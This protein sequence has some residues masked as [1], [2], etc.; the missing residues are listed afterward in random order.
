[1]A[2]NFFIDLHL[3]QFQQAL[4]NFKRELQSLR[5]G[6][7]STILVEEVSV[8]AYGSMQPLKQLAS[9]SVPENNAIAISPWDK[10][11]MKDIEVALNKANLGLSI[12]N[13]GDKI[14]AKLPLMTEE[15][16]KAMVKL[17]GAKAEDARIVI[18]KIRDEVKTAIVNAEKNKEITE[19]DKYQNISE[20]DE[21]IAD[22]NKQVDGMREA[23]E[24]EIMTV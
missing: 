14:I 20:L 8:E 19:D 23:K 21:Y 17:L 4:E 3:T 15:N 18:R 2:R 5:T 16:R 13:T 9:L 22:L 11:V 1:M 24:K 12:V 7:A 6:R 10:S